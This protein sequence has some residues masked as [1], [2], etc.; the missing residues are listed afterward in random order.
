V[1][2]GELHDQLAEDGA[3]LLVKVLNDL[4]A[5]RQTSVVQDESKVTLAPKIQTYMAKINW[6][7]T[8]EAIYRRYRAI[9]EN[10]LSIHTDPAIFK[11][12]E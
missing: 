6:D 4:D 5:H 12:Q 9:G 10:V 3:S 2:Y 11:V 1:T 8:A 7:E